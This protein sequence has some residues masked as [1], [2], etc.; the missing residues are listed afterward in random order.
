MVSCFEIY[1]GKLFDLLNDRGIIKCLEDS[2]QQVQLPGLTEHKANNVDEL[3]NMMSRAHEQRSTGSTGANLESSRSHQV[4]QLSV[5]VSTIGKNQ[6][7]TAFKKFGQLSFIDLAGSERGADT[8]NNSKQ[9]RMEGAEINTSLLA[10][11]EVIRS[12]EKKHGHTPF[13]GSKLTQVLKDSFIGDKTRTCM[14]ACVSP[15]M[16]NCE[17]TLNTLRYAD[18]VKEHQTQSQPQQPQQP[19]LTRFKSE[20]VTNEFHHYQDESEFNRGNNRPLTTQ[21]MNTR[22]DM[23]ISNN[24]YDNRPAT[25]FPS[26]RDTNRRGSL[27]NVGSGSNISGSA[28]QYSQPP[29]MNRAL[30]IGSNSIKRSQNNQL[31]NNNSNSADKYTTTPIQSQVKRIDTSYQN[32]QQQLQQQQSSFIST[33]HRASTGIRLL[34]GG[35]NS[36]GV[37]QGSNRDSSNWEMVIFLNLFIFSF[38][39]L[40]LF[41]HSPFDL[42]SFS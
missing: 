36:V 39:N 21:H 42:F 11:K 25:S 41:F 19:Q 34:R 17:H 13:R 8:T 10:L 33:N 1:G 32:Q 26:G 30:S 18:R 6:K 14:V 31:Q 2:K 20:S 38:S 28:I 3:L 5:Q 23:M 12:L 4:L 40:Y 37:N 9:T 24:L 15:N 22:D 35:N 16:S 7:P 27:D 29:T